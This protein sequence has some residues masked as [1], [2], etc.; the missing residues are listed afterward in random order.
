MAWIR[1]GHGSSRQ[2]TWK[3]RQN[4]KHDDGSSSRS[5]RSRSS[6]TGGG[7]SG[8]GRSCGMLEPLSKFFEIEK[9]PGMI[10]SFAGPWLTAYCLQSSHGQEHLSYGTFFWDVGVEVVHPGR[11][12]SLGDSIWSPAASE[13]QVFRVEVPPLRAEAES[14]G[15]CHRRAGDLKRGPCLTRTVKSRQDPVLQRS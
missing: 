10:T 6:R 12:S 1:C 3:R 4:S 11:A 13:L 15:R 8:S 5:S 9:I 14:R 7:R 2:T